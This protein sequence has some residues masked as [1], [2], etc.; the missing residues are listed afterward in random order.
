M[1]FPKQPR[2]PLPSL[3]YKSIFYGYKYPIVRNSGN[4]AQL[5][6]TF[7]IF[8]PKS[9]LQIVLGYSC[10]LQ[11]LFETPTFRGKDDKSIE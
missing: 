8:P 2:R 1:L 7:V 11:K 5:L 4:L 6:N 9:A 10:F 3:L